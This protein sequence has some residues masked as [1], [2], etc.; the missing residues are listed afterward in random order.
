[1]LLS[2]YIENVALIKKLNIDINAG[3]TVLT[4]ETGGGKSIIIDSL[5]LLCGSRGDR[6]LI[7][8]GEDFACVEGI[9][10]LR[11]VSLGEDAELADNDQTVTVYRRITAD[12][13]SVCKA[14]GRTIS[15]SKLKGIV[16]RLVNIHGQQDTQALSDPSSH[17][18]LLDAYAGHERELEAYAAS[19][20]AYIAL[21]DEVKR[22]GKINEDKLIRL[23]VL[24]FQINEL[25]GANIIE[26]EEEG[27]ESEKSVL[28]NYEKILDNVKTALDSLDGRD[29]A[30]MGL[31]KAQEALNRLEGVLSGISDYVKR[32]ESCSYEMRDIVDSLKS[33]ISIDCDSPEKRIDEIEERLALISRLKRKYRTD[34]AGLSEK[35]KALKKEKEE[36]VTSDE[37][38]EDRKNELTDKAKLLQALA[39]TLSIKRKSAALKLE[40]EIEANLSQL[41]MPSVTFATEFGRTPFTPTGTDTAEFLIS[42][43]AGEEPRSIARIASGGE[44][45]RIMLSV[46]SAFAEIDGVTT[47]VFDEIDT[48]I[49]GKTSERIGL[50]LKKLTEPGIQILCVTHS[51][52]IAC[53]A[54]THLSVSKAEDGGRTYTS[55]KELSFEER[56]NE[57]AR[58]MGGIQV[59]EAVRAASREALVRAAELKSNN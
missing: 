39:D 1:M 17:L 3:F 33:D 20:A 15:V 13:R 8:T 56:I 48:G 36:L 26:G 24:E 29:S 22:L 12:G 7:R 9:F 5:A 46:K 27:L 54:D 58:I 47:V 59:T 23:D 31:Y 25:D 14:G 57:I 55:V 43:N 50:K 38:L 10:D 4:G 44:L 45:S 34:E 19:Y 37:I 41:D 21:E 2:L 6:S 11:G 28:V 16:S 30:L 42:A 53:L 32:L 51:P 18:N 49:S 52:Q 40:K 35:L